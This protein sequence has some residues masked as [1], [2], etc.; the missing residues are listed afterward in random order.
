MRVLSFNQKEGTVSL[1]ITNTNDLWVLETLLTKGC[2]VESKTT[3]MI[4]SRDGTERGERIA[5]KLRI[6]VEKVSYEPF[7]DSLRATG[8][9]VSDPD[10]IGVLGSYHTLVIRVGSIV[11]IIKDTWSKS[12][13]DELKRENSLNP[14]LII[15]VDYDEVALAKLWD[16][17]VQILGTWFLERPGKQDEKI[18]EKLETQII[19]L[20]TELKN[21]IENSGLLVFAGPT[22]LKKNKKPVV[23]YAWYAS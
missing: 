5:T 7:T 19:K 23:F 15:S 17:G 3:R 9:V 14:L 18:D 4:K 13:L 6:K 2:E 22:H 10:E 12:E 16:Y 21:Y 11:T 1:Q 20:A 8:R